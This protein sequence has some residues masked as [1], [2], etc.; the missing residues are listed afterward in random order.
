L[1]QRAFFSNISGSRKVT[2][3]ALKR[4]CYVLRFLL[5]DRED[6]RLAFYTG[7]GRV[8]VI[9]SREDLTL[10]PEYWF[11]GKEYDEATRGLGAVPI[12]P[13]SSAGEENILCEEDDKYLSEDILI[14]ELAMGIL[15]L[16]V[17]KA[18]PNL[19]RELV[20]HY[21]HAKMSGWWR[22]T[23]A[24]L[25]PDSYFVRTPVSTFIEHLHL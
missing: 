13:V 5:A 8:A 1:F 25:S 12:I 11:L 6:L 19:Y 22:N 23:Y 4:A 16:A 10:L 9:A 20:S 21:T 14:R 3:E 18:L 24:I 2:D 7:H 15:K 17:P